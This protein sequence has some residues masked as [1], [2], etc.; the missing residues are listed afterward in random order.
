VDPQT[1]QVPEALT[2]STSYIVGSFFPLI[3]YFFLPIRQ[4]LP[5][6]IALTVLALVIVGIIKGRLANLN[7]LI[8]IVE[9]VV[10]GGLSALGGYVL[11][12]LIPHLLGY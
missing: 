6:S 9:V 10:V 12:V 8:S 3:A 7:M 4:A 5:V 11:G 1:V 2:M